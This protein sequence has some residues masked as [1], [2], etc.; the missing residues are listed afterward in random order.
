M[1]DDWTKSGDGSLCRAH[2]VEEC[3]DV[4]AGEDGSRE[5]LVSPMALKDG[6]TYCVLDG[7]RINDGRVAQ[8][9]WL[10]EWA[11]MPSCRRWIT[12]ATNGCT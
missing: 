6:W 10:D 3:I 11:R 12:L 7:A 9:G 1:T 5:S 2:L 8:L 4:E